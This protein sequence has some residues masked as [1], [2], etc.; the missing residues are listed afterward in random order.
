[1]KIYSRHLFNFPKTADKFLF[2]NAIDCYTLKFVL[3]SKQLINIQMKNLLLKRQNEISNELQVWQLKQVMR[4]IKVIYK[5]T[6]NVASLDYSTN[7]NGILFSIKKYLLMMCC[8]KTSKY[9]LSNK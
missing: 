1:M 8:F 9:H 2:H 5:E 6:L 3:L 4:Y 7:Y